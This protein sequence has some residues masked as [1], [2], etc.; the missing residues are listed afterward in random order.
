MSESN[1]QQNAD[2]RRG[3]KAVFVDPLLE[4]TTPGRLLLLAFLAAS[5]TI[6]FTAATVVAIANWTEF[7]PQGA[8]GPAGEVGFVGSRGPIGD[9]GRLGK[10]GPRGFPGPSG[11]SG[12]PGSSI[13]VCSDF[14]SDSFFTEVPYC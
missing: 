1:E 4:L 12:P 7:L 11:R 9:S 3:P 2:G 10:T 14:S 6:V 13:S 5:V 8:R